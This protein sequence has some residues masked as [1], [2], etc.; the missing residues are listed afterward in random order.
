MATS[1]WNLQGNTNTTSAN[2]LGTS[3]NQPLVVKTANTERLRIDVSGN[4]GVGTST[5]GAKLCVDPQGEGG[6]KVGGTNG[7][8]LDLTVSNQNGRAEIQ[9][10]VVTTSGPDGPIPLPHPKAESGRH[11]V[12]SNG[13]SGFESIWRQRRHRYPQSWCRTGCRGNLNVSGSANVGSLSATSHFCIQ[14]ERHSHNR[15]R[16]RPVQP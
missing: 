8:Q 1:S 13:E 16:Q 11:H 10:W 5:P 7:S 14:P 12:I 6:I 15:L 9:S 4:I 3:D 2:F